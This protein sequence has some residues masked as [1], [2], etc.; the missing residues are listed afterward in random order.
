MT[1]HFEKEGQKGEDD[2][3]CKATFAVLP[4]PP[5][6][7]RDRLITPGN[8]FIVTCDDDTVYNGGAFFAT[9]QLAPGIGDSVVAANTGIVAGYPVVQVDGN[10]SGPTGFN[11]ADARLYFSADHFIRGTCDHTIIVR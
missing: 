3:E 5:T 4:P 2:K 6:Q 1:C 7:M 8:Q 10:I 11:D 9:S